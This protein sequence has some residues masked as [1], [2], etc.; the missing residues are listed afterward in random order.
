[1]S[2]IRA[3]RDIRVDFFRGVA[4]WW[5][6]T[7]HIP[8]DVLGNFSLRNFAFCDATEIFV[9]LA[10]YAGG[11][12]Y[13][14]AM[15]RHGWLYAG[16]DVLR[17]AWTIYVAHIF[18]F[19]V[20]AAQ[21]SYSAAALDKA[22]Y[23]DEIHL[24][25]LADEPYR[26]LMEALTLHF[27]PGYLNIL[28]LY[29]VLLLFFAVALPLLRWPSILATLSFGLY[30][31]ARTVPL[32]FPSLTGGAWFFDPMAW[33]LLFMLGAILSYAP[34]KPTVRPRVL[35]IASVLVVGFGLFVQLVVWPGDG[36]TAHMP[37]VVGQF[38]MSVDKD[39][40][41]PFRLVSILAL[42]W[43]T[44]RLVP[45]NARWLRSRFTAPFT[46]MGQH[47]LPVFCVSIG[48]SF[49]GRLAM[50]RDDGL[51]A[52][53]GVNALGFAGM[54]AVGVLGA[55]YRTKGEQPVRR[56]AALSNVRGTDTA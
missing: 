31:A 10:G 43:L 55:W 45:S 18:M 52:Q 20:F 48:L 40:L 49:L 1:M 13:G 37:R 53:I 54:T 7:D 14:R 44:T 51:L 6:F 38:L 36:A 34:G 17:R 15:D 27:Q 4:L 9:L 50:E 21:V 3:G 35:D 33:Q 23:L 29:I 26:A 41:H 47:S 16:A 12:V 24:D 19:V 28:P 25:V 46:V 56:P 2:L 42:A 30:A 32:Q 8:G 11:I 22:E 5:I 39:K